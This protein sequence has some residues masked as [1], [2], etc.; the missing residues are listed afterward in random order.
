MLI[1]L[2][3]IAQESKDDRAQHAKDLEAKAAA[4]AKQHQDWCRVAHATPNAGAPVWTRHVDKAS[5]RPYW[6][7]AAKGRTTWDDPSAFVARS[8]VAL[9]ADSEERKRSIAGAYARRQRGRGLGDLISPDPAARA[10]AIAATT[11]DHTYDASQAPTW[12]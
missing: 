10:R 2:E 3:K 8:R 9:T 1:S 7:N 6:Y 12:S 5:G 4:D 11:G